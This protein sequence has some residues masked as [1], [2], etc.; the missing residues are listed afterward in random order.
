MKI[1]VGNL[2]ATTDDTQLR[3]AFT[4]HGEVT[5]AVVVRDRDSQASRGFGFV[6]MPAAADAQTAIA[7]LNGS[8]LGGNTLVVNEARSRESGP[9]A[10]RGRSDRR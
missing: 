6:E 4:S 8:A 9:G 2:N 3:E 7:S 10:F 1:Y 5:S